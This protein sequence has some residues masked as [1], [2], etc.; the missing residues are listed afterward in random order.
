MF[1][2]ATE[3]KMSVCF[4][5]VTVGLKREHLSTYHAVLL[6]FSYSSLLNKDMVFNT[7]V[8]VGGVVW[9]RE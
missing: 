9:Q 2:V 8:C 5:V 3:T 1:G 6:R 4:G 7:R